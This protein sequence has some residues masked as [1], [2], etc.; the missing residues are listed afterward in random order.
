MLFESAER[1]QEAEPANAAGRSEGAALEPVYLHRRPASSEAQ[2]VS[3]RWRGRVLPV[4]PA[5]G[6][7]GECGVEASDQDRW[8]VPVPPS[9]PVPVAA[10]E[11]VLRLAISALPRNEHD[12]LSVDR[13]DLTGA[14]PR[15]YLVRP[16]PAGWIV[17]A[18]DS[19]DRV[20]ATTPINSRLPAVP[21]SA[22]RKRPS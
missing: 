8:V 6:E 9:S 5:G 3:L 15:N 1:S 7:D 10:L 11:N 2:P 20:L 17:L 22:S 21:E 4:L 14:L 19:E 16:T 13:I 18:A 12:L